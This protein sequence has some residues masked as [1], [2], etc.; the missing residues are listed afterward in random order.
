MVR[1][2]VSTGMYCS[3][4]I[5]CT[6]TLPRCDDA[7]EEEREHSQ[8]PLRCPLSEQS[9]YEDGAHS[10]MPGKGVCINI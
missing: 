2:L 10:G 8:C 1:E 7:A 6:G 5:G 4:R 3:A 9:V